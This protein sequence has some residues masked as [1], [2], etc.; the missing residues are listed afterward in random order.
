M[1]EMTTPDPRAHCGGALLTAM[2]FEARGFTDALIRD[3]LGPPDQ[4]RTN[5]RYRGDPPKHNA[6]RPGSAIFVLSYLSS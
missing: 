3:F 2:G 1:V 6:Q 5:P 4:T